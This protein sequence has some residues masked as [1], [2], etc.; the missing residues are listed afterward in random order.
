[1]VASEPRAPVRILHLSDLHFRA[2]TAWDREPVLRHLAAA[3]GAEVAQGL[4][5]D[6]VAITGDLAHSGKA[7][8][9]ALA[10]RWLAEALW[11]TLSAKD[12]PPLPRD[13]L[14]LVPGNHDVDREAVD[15]IAEAVQGALLAG[16]DQDRIA[17]ILGSAT[18][19]KVLLKRHNAY[20]AFYAKW[21]EP[22]A[23]ATRPLPWWQRRIEI[24]G[25]CLHAAGLDS[26]WMA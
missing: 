22:D 10:R 15:E 5:P 16:C 8:E 26:A 2:D 23:K 4:A 21:L 14:L 25:Q 24:Q 7:A 6:L 3:I 13:R 18:Q 20:L 17:K 11:P 9:Y 1:M 19:R 12:A